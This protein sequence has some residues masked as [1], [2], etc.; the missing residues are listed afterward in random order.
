MACNGLAAAREAQAQGFDA[1]VLASI[2]GPMAR[3]IRT[4]V[5]IPVVGYGEAA[6]NLAG[7]Y[8]RRAGMLVFYQGQARL[9][10]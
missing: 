7:L 8:G 5:D 6:F 9:L 4:I 10:A 3:E 2:A 1:M